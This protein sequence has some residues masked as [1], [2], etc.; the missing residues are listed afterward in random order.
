MIFCKKKNRTIFDKKKGKKDSIAANNALIMKQLF[1]NYLFE[2]IFIYLF[3]I[4]V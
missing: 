3:Y 1:P 2:Q 4:Y